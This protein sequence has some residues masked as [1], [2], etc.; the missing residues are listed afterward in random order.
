[1]ANPDPKWRSPEGEVIACVERLK[2]LRENV[3]EIRRLCQD[4]LEDAVLMDCDEHQF[5]AVLKK[6]MDQLDNPYRKP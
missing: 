1:M 6:L 4:A 5:R 3:E 2:V